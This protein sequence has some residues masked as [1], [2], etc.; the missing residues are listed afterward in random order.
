MRF[1]QE[2]KKWW[3]E[4]TEITLLLIVMSIGVEI[5][6]GGLS[7]FLDFFGGIFLPFMLMLTIYTIRKLLLH[8]D[9][10][11]LVIGEILSRLS[12]KEH[13]QNRRQLASS[14]LYLSKLR[15][16]M[17]WVHLMVLAV[18]FLYVFGAEVMGATPNVCLVIVCLVLLILLI[19]R[20]SLIRYRIERGYFGQNKNEARQ[21]I[22]F[23]LK[24]TEKIDFTDSS[25][26]PMKALLPIQDKKDKLSINGE[27]AIA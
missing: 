22:S 13:I 24:N 15:R 6:F 27:G 7:G 23:I 21:L 10:S 5:L 8:I 11:K 16:S 26:K 19:L 1:L 4:I 20:D 3:G 14:V 2:I 25:G 17:V 12:H 18:T 9:N